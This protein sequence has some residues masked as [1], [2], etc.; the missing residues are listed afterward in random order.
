MLTIGQ[1]AT[2]AGVTV[3]AI[4]VYH[5]KGL[6]PEPER[7]ASGYRRYD[8]QAVIEVSRIVTLAQAGVPLARIPD[9]L[10]A[11]GD[12]VVEQIE[13][14][15]AELRRTIRLLEQ[16][17][18]RLQH[19]GRPDRLCLPAEAIQYMDRLRVVGL[20]A[21]HQDAIRDSWILGYALAPELARAIL[22]S[23]TA[24]LDDEEYLAMLRGYDDAIDWNPDD[25]RLETLADATAAVARRMT[26]VPDL[27]AFSH[28]AP[29]VVDLLTGHLGADS[30]AWRQL[31]RLLA[32]RL[33]RLDPASHS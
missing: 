22:P 16:R 15:D 18:S 12:A 13:Q 33:R 5:A 27:P 19:L 26:V 10:D 30:A 20:S 11:D 3:K 32:E 1:L 17:R 7:D 31:D 6:L 2:H 8:A 14:I 28:V 21:R 25:P 24:L 23:H 4:R 29:E 9:V